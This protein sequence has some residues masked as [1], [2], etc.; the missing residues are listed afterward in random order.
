MPSSR[1]ELVTDYT[2]PQ[3]RG[4]RP[5]IGGGTAAWSGEV[6]R[7]AVAERRFGGSVTFTVIECADAP[8]IATLRLCCTVPRGTLPVAVELVGAID[9]RSGDVTLVGQMPATLADERESRPVA[10][11]ASPRAAPDFR[12]FR[13]TSREA[14][15]ARFLARGER[16][17]RI[18]ALLGISPHTARR[19]T[20][21]VMLKLGVHSRAA[22]GAALRGERE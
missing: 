6:T 2:P 4:P 1:V 17:A 8:D 18:A 20:E 16:N 22:V 14:D 21:S 11:Y 5:A 9:L 7:P 13:L 10:S 19:H 3:G 15:V 12:Q